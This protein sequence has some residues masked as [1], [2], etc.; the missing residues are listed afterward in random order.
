MTSA[1]HEIKRLIEEAR[2]EVAEL[3][4]VSETAKRLREDLDCSGE[5]AP[6]FVTAVL[7]LHSHVQTHLQETRWAIKG[8]I[9]GALLK[10]HPTAAEVAETLDVLDT[11][12]NSLDARIDEL[13]QAADDA[14]VLI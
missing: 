1:F 2:C 5:C 4:E 13:H 14:G 11:I 6:Q 8:R 3:I 10:A 7:S 12:I 9:I